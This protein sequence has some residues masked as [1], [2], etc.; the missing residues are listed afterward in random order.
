[1]SFSYTPYAVPLLVLGIVMAELAGHAWRHRAMHPAV[2]V[3]V[4]LMISITIW[5]CGYALELLGADLRTKLFWAQVQY[6]GIG[7]V[8]PLWLL[9]ALEY[10]GRGRLLSL[11]NIWLLLSPGMA[12]LVA[13][14]TNG[15]HRLWWPEVHMDASGPFL[16]LVVGHGPL[17]WAYTAI[18]YVY[19]FIGIVLYLLA[20]WRVPRLYRWQSIVMITAA[21]VPVAGNAIYLSHMIPALGGLDLTPFAFAL[22]G[23]LLSVGLFR[24]RLLDIIPVAQR[25]VLESMSEGVIVIDVQGRI[26]DINPAAQQMLGLGKAELIGQK[27]EEVLPSAELVARLHKEQAKV[28][29]SIGEGDARRWLEASVSPLADERGH[30][31]GQLIVLRDITKERALEELRD[32]MTSMMVHDLRNPLTNLYMA[33]EILS[34][35]LRGTL[36]PEMQGVM[37]MAMRS[38]QRAVDLVNAILDVSRL[39]SGRMSLELELISPAALIAD[40]VQEMMPAAERAGLTLETDIPPTLPSVRADARLLRRVLQNLLGNAIKFTPSGGKVKVTAQVE[41][42]LLT[43]SVSDTGPGI[44]PELQKR[45]FRKFIT[46][47][48]EKRGSGLGLAFCKLVVEAHGGE[49]GVQSQVGQGSTFT[50]SIPVG[51]PSQASGR[52]VRGTRRKP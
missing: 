40:T 4:F 27:A 46:G 38:G 37:E 15:W 13:V 18:A 50:F 33:L 8:S 17:F 41:R 2:R 10:T 25:A 34:E 23:A 35:D 24:F 14:L 21:L 36:S 48:H 47:E 6:L 5:A 42:D 49:I 52:S 12:S 22:S 3:F 11:R 9:L 20:F 45:L 26:V 19:I 1:V 16:T 39:E 31:L 28:D 29:I 7:F 43:V 32:D 30:L 44:S 51:G